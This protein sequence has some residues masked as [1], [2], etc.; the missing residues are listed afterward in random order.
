MN[1]WLWKSWEF[2][3]LVWKHN[4]KPRVGALPYPTVSA[5]KST[6][7]CKVVRERIVGGHLSVRNRYLRMVN[8]KRIRVASLWV[9]DRDLQ[10]LYGNYRTCFIVK[11]CRKR[12]ETYSVHSVLHHSL[13][14]MRTCTFQNRLSMCRHFDRG[15]ICTD[16]F[17]FNKLT[18]NIYIKN[19]QY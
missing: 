15:W 11:I 10:W 9:E 5:V 7:G 13:K 17:L 2:I 3:R 8:S 12:Y 14:S 19:F 6:V 4:L 18:I 1:I 16:P